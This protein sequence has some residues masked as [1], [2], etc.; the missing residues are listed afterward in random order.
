MKLTLNQLQ[1]IAYHSETNTFG[2]ITDV[3]I[4]NRKL[5]IQ[6][7]D[8]DELTVLLSEVKFL[9][10]I[11]LI[12]EEV[13]INGDV[14]AQLNEDDEIVTLYEVELQD[15]G[16][17]L[18]HLLD[19]N[20]ERVLS[21]KPLE[22]ESLNLFKDILVPVGN[23]NDIYL[24][25][26]DIDE[27]ELILNFNINIVKDTKDNTY[28]YACNNKE[29][30]K[31]DL[32]KVVFIGAN[33]LEEEYARITIDK[34]EYVEYI[35]SETLVNASSSELQSYAY[36]MSRPKSPVAE[37]PNS[38]LCYPS[39]EEDCQECDLEDECEVCHENCDC[40]SWQ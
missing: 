33:L 31:I 3:D 25:E 6:D 20:Q 22:K 37:L 28:Y 30:D 17:V 29:E 39:C 40:K 8:G 34:E 13:V 15:D 12:G 32:I 18:F 5:T 1:G 19:E 4:L 23:I 9:E 14:L 24:F 16:L 26:D 21:G 2:R 27:D 11:G 10:L 36:Q 7:V 35:K 38:N